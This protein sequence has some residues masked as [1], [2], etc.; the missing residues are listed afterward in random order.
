[1]TSA[2]FFRILG[3]PELEKLK[4]FCEN[5]D[6]KEIETRVRNNWMHKKRISK[7]LHEAVIDTTNRENRLKPWLKKVKSKKQNLPEIML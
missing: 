3:K 4:D 2:A 7:R 5:V 1:M 6:L